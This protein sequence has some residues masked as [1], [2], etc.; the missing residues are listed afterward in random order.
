MQQFFDWSDRTAVTYHAD[1]QQLNI[2]MRAVWL[3]NL[4]LRTLDKTKSVLVIDSSED[5]VARASQYLHR[6]GICHS[7]LDDKL[8]ESVRVKTHNNFKSGINRIVVATTA[9]IAQS[10]LVADQIVVLGQELAITRENFW[11]EPESLIRSR[12]INRAFRSHDLDGCDIHFFIA[13]EGGSSRCER[14]YSKAPVSTQDRRWMQEY[15]EW[16]EEKRLAEQED[17]W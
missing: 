2:G 8:S 12:K 3:E 7:R 16:K 10:D 1:Y 14:L 6:Q 4:I 17:R 11:K 15:K 5:R 13:C 9:Y